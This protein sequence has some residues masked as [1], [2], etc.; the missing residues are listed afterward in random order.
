MINFVCGNIL[1]STAYC[2][3]NTVNCDG[4][5]GKGIAYQ[6]KLKYP[7]NNKS[8]IRACRSGQLRPGK[9]HHYYE[10]NKLIIN[11]PT[12]NHWKGNSKIEYIDSGLDE[13]RNYIL[14]FKIQSIAIPPLGCGNGGLKWDEVKALILEKLKDLNETEIFIYEPS[15]NFKGVAS[16]APNLTTSHYVIMQFKPRLKKFNK[17]RIQKTA[18]FFNIFLKEKYFK[19]DKYT[20][21]PYSYAI[22]LLSKDIK[23]FQNYYNLSTEDSINL[24]KSI[25]TSKN[26]D[27]KL[28]K[29]LPVI[30]QCTSYI[31]AIKTDKEVE[32]LSTICYII[33]SS[34]LASADDIILGFRKWSEEKSSKFSD[35]QILS[36]IDKLL[37][38]LIIECDMTGKYSICSK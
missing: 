22:D 24:V 5:M 14:N 28:A 8:Y 7:G 37:N 23:N 3:V 1:E 17:L 27:D 25:I 18:Y 20:Y 2:L 35:N 12:K 15:R 30:D 10:E 31:N 26:T 9:L 36:G 21:G 34:T 16:K 13:L 19:F 4:Y 11:F 38:D 6:F 32:L 29:F 33:E